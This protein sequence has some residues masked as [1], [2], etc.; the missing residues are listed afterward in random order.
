MYLL[1]DI[2]PTHLR[3]PVHLLLINLD[4]VFVIFGIPTVRGNFEIFHNQTEFD[5]TVFVCNWYI[6][7]TKAGLI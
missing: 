3:M 5:V 7:I 2:L 1:K 6:I 4:V